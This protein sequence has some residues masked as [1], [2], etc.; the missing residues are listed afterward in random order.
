MM[1]TDTQTPCDHDWRRVAFPSM[2]IKAY[3]VEWMCV[4]CKTRRVTSQ[5][6]KA[7][8]VEEYGRALGVGIVRAGITET[9]TGEAKNDQ[10]GTE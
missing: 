7:H 4:Q 3:E 1:A 6:R 9:E 2:P 5:W 10:A 8:E